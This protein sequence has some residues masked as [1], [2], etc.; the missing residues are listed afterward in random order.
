[1]GRRAVLLAIILFA[2][3]SAHAQVPPIFI[4]G[5]ELHD[6]YCRAC[7]HFFPE[8]LPAD[9]E[10]RLDRAIC[11][12]SAIRGLTANWDRLPPAAKEAFAFLQQRPILSHSIL[13]SGG[14]FKIHYDTVGI[15]AVAP[16]DTDANGVPDYVDEAAR[17]FEDVWD[18]EINQLGYNPPPSDGDGVYDVYIKNLAFLRAYGYAWPIVPR[19]LTTP[20]YIEI[21]NN[22]AEN[23]YESRGLDGLRVTAAHEFFHAIQFGYYADFAAAWW[24]EATATWME[25][26][27]YPEVNDFYQYMSCPSYYSCFYDDPEASLDK[28]SGSR[29]PF[30]ASIFAHHVE[31]VYGADVIKGVWELLK[32]RD[33]SKYSLSLIDDGMPLGEFAQVMPRFAAWNYLTDE[34][35]RP[36]YYVEARDLPS[37]KHANIPLGTGGSFEGS[38]TVDHLGTTYLRVDT[39][40]IFGGLRGVFSLDDQGDWTLLVMLISPSGVELLYPRGTTVIIPGANRFDE[41]VFIVMETSLSGERRRVNYTLSTGGSMA[42]DL[43]CDVDGD[44]RVAFSDFLRFGNGFKLLHTDSNYDPKLDF[45]GDGPVDFLDFLIFVSHFGELR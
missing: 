43:V 10:F 23:I 13:S 22:Y 25:D 45:N 29:H 28:D 17:V 32:K 35:A 21:D 36:G 37:I 24:Q 6:I 19:E 15:H 30:G 3:K 41:V 26:V 31:Q 7:A 12:T 40:N 11:G 20:S 38:E 9:S 18:L 4:P 42:T 8:V 14:H 16:T 1:M 34:R 5:T 44:G 2:G 39:S 27:A 33:S